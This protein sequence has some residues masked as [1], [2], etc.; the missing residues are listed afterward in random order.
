M[1]WVKLDDKLPHHPKVR[2]L[3]PSIAKPAYGLY[4]ASI[5]FCQHYDTDGMIR[6]ADLH[7]ILPSATKPTTREIT[8]LV[9]VGLWEETPSGWCVH[10]YLEHNLSSG[11]RKQAQS[12]NKTRQEKYRDAL[13]N[14]SGN[15]SRNALQTSP[16]PLPSQ[17]PP[18]P[19]PNPNPSPPLKRPTDG[20]SANGPE[21]AKTAALR[22]PTTEAE[23]LAATRIARSPP[24]GPR[25][26]HEAG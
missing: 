19:L 5:Q 25:G 8:A 7:L 14:A 4:V 21:T 16:P 12:A 15:A 17:S 18:N 23:Y 26:S 13:R 9:L 3:P 11:E 2:A 24:T 22:Y 1:S 6:R 20:F 10:D